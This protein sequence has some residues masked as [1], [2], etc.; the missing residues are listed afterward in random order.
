[1]LGLATLAGGVLCALLSRPSLFENPI[2]SLEVSVIDV[3]QGDAILVRFPD[4]TAMLVDA[5]PRTPAFDSGSRVVAPLLARMGVSRLTYLVLTHGHAD[6]AGGMEGVLRSIPVDTIVVGA[7]SDTVTRRPL[8]VPRRRLNAGTI[9]SPTVDSRVYVLWPRPGPMPAT[10][11]ENNRS[12]VLK[13]VFGNFSILLT[14]DAEKGV[15]RLLVD[16]YAKFLGS[17]VLKVAH[18][19]SSTGTSS[20]FLDAVRPGLA[21]MSVGNLNRFGH[22]SSGVLASLAG[23]CPVARTDTDGCVII[24][25]DGRAWEREDWRGEP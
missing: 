12:L 1:M 22:P 9:L 24:R 15:E 25:T 23:R 4:E 16:R 3:G 7:W 10:L 2:R 13:V 11:P 17:T 14:G 19:G 8:H 20:P 6:H 18:H 5:G 21:V